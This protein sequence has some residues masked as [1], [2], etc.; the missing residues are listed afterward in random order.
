MQLIN[1]DCIN[2]I[3]YLTEVIKDHVLNRVSNYTRNVT[4]EDIENEFILFM[5]N[6]K[7]F[8]KIKHFN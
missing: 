4:E 5:D 2:K 1:Q 3:D 6:Y 7:L 8:L